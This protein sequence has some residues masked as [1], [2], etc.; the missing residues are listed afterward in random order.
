MGLAGVPHTLRQDPYPGVHDQS[1]VTMRS[2]LGFRQ[3]LN[4]LRL[5]IFN[6]SSGPVQAHRNVEASGCAHYPP[7]VSM[8]GM[9]A[10]QPTQGAM[11]QLGLLW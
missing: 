10:A 11:H 7:S 3:Y 6:N 2:D 1:Q 5:V 9:F 8:P 4:L